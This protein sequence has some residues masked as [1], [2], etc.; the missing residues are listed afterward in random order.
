[1]IKIDGIAA[2]PKFYP[3]TIDSYLRYTRRALFLDLVIN[4]PTMV[5]KP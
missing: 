1:M 3:T 2:F 4:E 5:L